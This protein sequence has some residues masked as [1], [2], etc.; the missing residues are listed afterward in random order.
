MK[1]LPI[2]EIEQME[3]MLTDSVYDLACNYENLP[4]RY[5]LRRYLTVER[6]KLVD[7]LI[8]NPAKAEEYLQ[9]HKDICA[10][11]DVEKIYQQGAKYI[12]ASMNRGRIV[13]SK[14]FRSLPKAVAEHVFIS[15]GM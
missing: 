5:D 9:K 4:A 2:P 13:Y 8:E 1:S 12:I 10:T 6:R 14:K 3:A 7:Y 11:H 15:Y